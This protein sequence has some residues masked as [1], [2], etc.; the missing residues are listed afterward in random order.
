MPPDPIRLKELENILLLVVCGSIVVLMLYRL[1]CVPKERKGLTQRWI[2]E[3]EK[4][5]CR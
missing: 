5:Y 4:P 2:C 3:E 1:G